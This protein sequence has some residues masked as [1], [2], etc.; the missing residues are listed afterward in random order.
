M[1]KIFLLVF[2]LILNSEFVLLYSQSI[3]PIR[4]DVGFC[5]NTDEV[6]SFIKYLSKN[7][8]RQNT[9]PKNLVAG[10]SVHD[11]Y[12]YAGKVYYPLFKSIKTKEVIIF[13]VTHGT[14]RKEMGSLSNILIL[15]EFDKWKGPYGDVTISP[16]RELIKSGLPKEDFIVSNKAHSIEHSIEALIPFLQYYNRGIKITP[17][18]VTQMSFGKM[19]SV[20]ANISKIITEYIQKNKLVL[21]KDVFILISNDASHYG[22]DFDNSP[23]GLDAK[24]HTTATDNDRRIL[25]TFLE[26]MIGKSQTKS[27]AKEIWPSEDKTKITPLWC[28]RYPI[29]F[30]LLT[31]TNVVNAL[32][33]GTLHGKVFKYSDTFTEKVLPVKNTSMGITAVFSYK[34]W[35]GWFTEGIYLK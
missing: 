2:L 20:S 33:A 6:N 9:L 23:F 21:G 15:D 35:C 17:I 13:G 26:G 32:N 28:G 18:M 8:D 3:R 16:L 29:V 27:L 14:V 11:D 7:S 4:D 1:K 12:L 5:W 30:G 34:H 22:E 31:L 25:H 24:A 19:D 10:I